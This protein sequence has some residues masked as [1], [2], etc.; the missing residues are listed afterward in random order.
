MIEFPCV[1]NAPPNCGVVSST[2]FCN[3]VAPNAA[4]LI[5]T[6]VVVVFIL[7]KLLTSK[8]FAFKLPPK[9]ELYHQQ[10]LVVLSV[11]VRLLCCK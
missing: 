6:L 4:P 9:T 8:L 3:A 1:S 11:V 5:I 10:R 7:L 2:T